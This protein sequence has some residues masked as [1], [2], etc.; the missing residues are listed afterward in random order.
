[1]TRISYYSDLHNFIFFFIKNIKKG[2]EKKENG[3]EREWRRRVEG[4]NLN[5]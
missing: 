2:K 1:M 3:R 4:A 5:F